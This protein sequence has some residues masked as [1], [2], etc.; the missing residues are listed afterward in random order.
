MMTGLLQA[1]G[2]DAVVLG[3]SIL[4]E[5]HSIRKEMGV[6]PQVRLTFSV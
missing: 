3:K 6:C 1:T 4:T 5:M 2:G